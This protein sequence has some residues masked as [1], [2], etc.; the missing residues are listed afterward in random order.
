[1]EVVGWPI[2]KCVGVIRAE[3]TEVLL[4]GNCGNKHG[5]TEDSVTSGCCG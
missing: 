3:K 1:M 4:A 5:G 2:R